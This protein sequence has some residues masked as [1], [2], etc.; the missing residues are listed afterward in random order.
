M[1]AFPE[2]EIQLGLQLTFYRKTRVVFAR[3]FPA[4]FFVEP[5][6]GADFP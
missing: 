1:S 6:A 5:Q 2:R 3:E 4:P